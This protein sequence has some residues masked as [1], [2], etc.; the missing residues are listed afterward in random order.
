[1]AA[2]R[3]ME[4]FGLRIA[5]NGYEV[6]PIIPGEKR[7]AGKNWQKFDG[8]PDGVYDY[9]NDGKGD[10]GVG[11]K[12]RYT[13]AVDIDI[14]DEE[15]NSEVQEI[16]REVAGDTPLRRIGLAPKVLWAYRAEAD[17]TFPKVDTGMWL[18]QQGRASKVEILADGQQFVAAHIHPDTGKPYQWLDK[19]SVLTVK[20]DELPILTHEQAVEIKERVLKLFLGHGWTKKT[21]N[22]ITRLSN[23]VLDDDDDPFAAYRP[24]V[25]ISDEEL[26]RKLFLIEDNADHDTW[27]QIG[28][29]LYHQYDGNQYGFDL[30]DRW[31]ASAPNYDRAALEKR[32]PTFDNKNRDHMPITCRIVLKL[33]K[34][35]ETVNLKEVVNDFVQRI[36]QSSHRSDTDE[37]EAVCAEI[38][39][40]DLPNVAREVITGKVK[41]AWKA[42]TGENARIGFIRELIRYESKEII[43][44]PPWIKPWVYCSQTDLLF[45]MS[46]R[47]ELSR[48]AF[49][50]ANAR[51]MLTP[52]ERLEGKAVPETQPVDAALNLYQI[53]SVY[54]RMFMPGQ[55]PL[56]TYNEVDYANSYSEG[57][58]P[59]L[60]GVLSPVEEEAIEIFTG[61]FEHLIK[62]ERDRTIFLDFLTYIV[63]NP[64]QRVNWAVLLQ[65]AEGDGK[66]FFLEVLK[67]VLGE[68]NVNMISG[69]LLE[70]KY[71]PWAENALVCFI[72]DVRL[73]GQNRFDAV[74]T[75]KPM[76]TNKWVSIRRMNTNVYDVINTMNYIATANTKDALPVGEEDSRFFPI[77]TR[78]QKPEALAKFKTENPHY[79][80]RLY[81]SIQFAG[82]IRQFLL[83]RK[84]SEH[85]NPKARA[86]ISS[87][88]HEMVALNESEELL[89]LTDSLEEST[90]PDY[91]EFLLDSRKVADHFM[92]LDALA[93]R[94]KALNRLLSQYGFTLLGRIKI[95]GERRQYWSLKPDAWPEDQ[96]KLAAAIREYLDP[97]GL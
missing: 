68:N 45:N 24:K 16:V 40:T 70:E 3:Y 60:P 89:A 17:E 85:F 75:L 43:S 80:D 47:T 55:P 86:P 48:V 32:W 5:E 94:G 78:F 51:Y 67:A 87:S 15:I 27:F 93:P 31:S 96:L 26:E 23:P 1:M 34:E 83:T 19:K 65:G 11:I 82:A 49:N 10:H 59:E 25:Q 57:G 37:L 76:L 88:R 6:I 2:R 39:V 7:P 42:I 71:N 53:P 22:A 63:Q 14:L 52:T 90:E 74:N 29:A 20:R 12:S 58:I 28:M 72:E 4:E 8:S 56:Y 64:G 41:Q 91:S 13:P 50:A 36:I 44:A 35:V 97:D 69:K 18:D 77:F 66:S 38:K 61:H 95:N 81:G 33:A 21:R 30:W 54:N 46:N 84:L 79:Y 62:N 9:L 73:H 92:G